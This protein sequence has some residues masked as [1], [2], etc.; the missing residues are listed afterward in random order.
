MDSIILKLIVYCLL[1]LLM[2]TTWACDS[3]PQYFHESEYFGSHDLD[4]VDT[5]TYHYSDTV[6]IGNIGSIR[7]WSNHILISDTEYHKVWIF[8]YDL[9]Y[10][11]SV[12]KKGA[13]PGEF[14]DPPFICIIGDS[15]Y[16]F[17]FRYR[18][19]NIYDRSY[20][21]V[22]HIQLPNDLTYP[23]A[24]PI[25]T[26][27]HYISNSAHPYPATKDDY[28][29]KFKS[30]VIFDKDFNYIK[31]FLEYDDI[32]SSS[33]Y[34]AYA[35]NNRQVRLTNSLE[36]S[37]YALQSATYKIR[38]FD[39]NFQMQHYF[40]RKP[41]HFGPI[42][43]NVSFQETIQSIQSVIDF[44]SG[45]SNIFDMQYDNHNNY[46]YVYYATVKEEALLLR[47]PLLNKHYLQVYDNDYNVIYDDD[48]P[49][50]FAFSRNGTI[51]IRNKETPDY[52]QLIKYR[53]RDKS[54]K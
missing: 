28:Y 40:G 45:T 8:D 32:Y 53:L 4:I 3:D 49:G 34:E 21:L 41:L 27:N 7:S 35:R 50:I 16:L 29:T 13:G 2:F 47:S 44:I 12:G 1:T 15:L 33:R 37:F 14:R 36:D 51:Y 20:E 19:A 43:E 42:P 6:H 31:E 23:N 30:L 39:N 11:K 46:I 5:L 18:T 48:I 10:L 38:R 54:N 25:T 17:Q 9:N 52:L 26:G 22:D 24:C